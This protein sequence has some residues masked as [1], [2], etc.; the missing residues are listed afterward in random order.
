MFS[1]MPSYS[2]QDLVLVVAFVQFVLGM[3]AA[4]LTRHQNG[5]MSN[6]SWVIVALTMVFLGFVAGWVASRA[7][8][9][10]LHEV[11]R[12]QVASITTNGNGNTSAMQMAL[13]G[14]V[15]VATTR[16]DQDG[17]TNIDQSGMGSDTSSSTSTLSPTRT[18]S[19]RGSTTLPVSDESLLPSQASESESE[20]Q[21]QESFPVHTGEDVE[22][23]MPALTD[24][25]VP[26]PLTTGTYD[27]TTTLSAPGASLLAEVK[28]RSGESVTMNFAP[29]YGVEA[30]TYSDRSS[31]Q[32]EIAPIPP[33]FGPNNMA[34]GD[35]TGSM[36]PAVALEATQ[37]EMQE[38][39]QVT[40]FA[41]GNC[42][43]PPPMPSD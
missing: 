9:N 31:L 13:A 41:K 14:S 2:L 19:I 35:N 39:I 37:V 18:N 20:G 23:G 32:E 33:C 29:T 12:E 27:P 40:G 36:L 17:Q 34:C 16:Y 1:Q 24:E 3:T 8:E 6:T 4:V 30:D 10:R 7:Q 43:C 26:A 15:N 21:K 42:E 22:P 28:G 25:R 11:S 38:H 5:T